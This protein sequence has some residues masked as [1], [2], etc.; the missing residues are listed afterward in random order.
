[1]DNICNVLVSSSE[2]WTLEINGVY[3]KIRKMVK[4]EIKFKY[5]VTMTDKF[6]SGWG[7]AQNKI[8]K[9]IYCC[10]TY[11]EALIVYENANDHKD[12]KHINICRS[13]PYYSPETHLSMWKFKK[14]SKAWYK[15]GGFR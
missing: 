11:E 8:C 14:D 2:L 7:K 4:K 5:W 13:E 6:M 10:K 1:M 3:I 15:K 9:Y 12:Q